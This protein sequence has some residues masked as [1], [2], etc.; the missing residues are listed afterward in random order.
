MSTDSCTRTLRAQG[1]PS[2][3][4]RATGALWPSP[5]GLPQ[6]SDQPIVRAWEPPGE[7]AAEYPQITLQTEE[8]CCLQT[9]GLSMGCWDSRKS[10]YGV[11]R[12]RTRSNKERDKIQLEGKR[13]ENEIKQAS[14]TWISWWSNTLVC[15]AVVT[16]A[17]PAFLLISVPGN[18]PG[19]KALYSMWTCVQGV[20]APE[21]RIRDH[22][23]SVPGVPASWDTRLHVCSDRVCVSAC[24]HQWQT[25]TAASSWVRQK[26][27]PDVVDTRG[28]KTVTKGTRASKPVSGETIQS[29]RWTSVWSS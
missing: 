10:F 19:W 7:S 11:F 23:D 3:L 12:G 25:G 22:R 15:P 18:F 2:I 27:D 6:G 4:S 26:P 21:E 1:N 28:S 16:T 8:E 20:Q 13:V 14:C 17:S 24:A 9:M 29:W 5:L